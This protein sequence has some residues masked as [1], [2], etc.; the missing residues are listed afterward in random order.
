ML[1]IVGSYI[2]IDLFGQR[3]TF[4]SSLNCVRLDFLLQNSGE[5][6]SFA[7]WQI[8]GGL[9]DVVSRHSTFCASH[10]D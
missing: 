1:G 9:G 2:I 4:Y 7:V 10:I 8:Q 3:S 6:G 5:T